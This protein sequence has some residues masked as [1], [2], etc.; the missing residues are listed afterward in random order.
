MKKKLLSIV[1]DRFRALFAD[2]QATIDDHHA[3]AVGDVRECRRAL[4]VAQSDVAAAEEAKAAAQGK[5]DELQARLDA[6]GAEADAVVRVAQDAFDQAMA[7]EKAPAGCADLDQMQHE[8]A[9]ALN[10]AKE[11]RAAEQ[12]RM[13]TF[14]L[15][16][17]GHVKVV[18]R[19][20][21][22][23]EEARGR[24]N[25][26]Q[27]QL[28]L[29]IARQAAVEL[30]DATHAAIAARM[31]LNNALRACGSNA[32]HMGLYGIERIEY[33]LSDKRRAMFGSNSLGNVGPNG[34]ALFATH[35]LDQFFKASALSIEELVAA[36]VTTG[37][38]AQ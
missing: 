11:K 32:K 26:A 37:G 7:H 21:E 31:T 14:E 19:R 18:E 6:M 24:V 23:L 9:L 12:L 34:P 1:S 15:R 16:Q 33:W 3:E 5:V 27:S 30:D 20:D 36:E 8:A 25:K 35:T 29:A 22:E 10:A 17:Q 4:R 13:H 38:E 28:W 2:T